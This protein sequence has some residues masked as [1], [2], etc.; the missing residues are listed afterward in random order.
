MPTTMNAPAP[1]SAA[2]TRS[3][4]EDLVQQ[5]PALRAQWAALSQEREEHLR[6]Y[7]AA[8]EELR[9]GAGGTDAAVRALSEEARA[10]GLAAE[11]E[12]I[13]GK[14]A[15]AAAE[16]KAARAHEE[17]EE[18]LDR[19]AAL[20]RSAEASR[21][22]VEHARE[23]AIRSME[24]AAEA[25]EREYPLALK[26][27]HEFLLGAEA[28]V[29]GFMRSANGR[30]PDVGAA[31]ALRFLAE[32]EARGVSLAGV[33]FGWPRVLAN[34]TRDVHRSPS[35]LDY[36]GRERP[37]RLPERGAMGKRVDEVLGLPR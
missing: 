14:I 18:K 21:S 25:V 12:V 32:L 33:V 34:G 20:A 10:E 17:R 11:L 31:D 19:L 22:A 1:K 28:M 6:A 24:E 5:L 2:P 35:G 15:A 7:E 3:T 27:R 16:L 8:R 26:A 9:R 30:D 37:I 36:V 23:R 13:D 29:P 4:A